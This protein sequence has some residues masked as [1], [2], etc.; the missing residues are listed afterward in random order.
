[1]RRRRRE[2]VV[3]RHDQGRELLVV[4]LHGYGSDERQPSTLMP[5]S[6]PAYVLDPRGPHRVSPGFG[7]WL[8]ETGSSGVELAPT[9]AMDAAVER[10]VEVI[11]QGRAES[12][13]P[14]SRT[15]LYGY[16][17][18]ATL[19]LAVAAARPDLLGT[20][21]AGAGFLPPDRPVPVAAG[22]LD[23]LVMNGDLDPVVTPALHDETVA[24]LAA[25]GHRVRSRR[26]AV[27]HV[28]DAAQARAADE[29]IGQQV[30][31]R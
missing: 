14:P 19:A 20:V 30:T 27:P 12:G 26:D 22:P 31:I 10:V 18:G 24:R 4:R 25:A 5:V 9:A 11:E 3:V 7:W 15:T 6:A 1:M 2:P 13:I 28:I 23:I 16:S 8:P 17:Q 21:V 29:F